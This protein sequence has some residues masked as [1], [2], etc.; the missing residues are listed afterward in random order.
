MSI[1]R[2][3]PRFKKGQIVFTSGNVYNH[4]IKDWDKLKVEGGK[5]GRIIDIEQKSDRNDDQWEHWEYLVEFFEL[6]KSIWLEEVDLS[7]DKIKESLYK[8]LNEI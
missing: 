2:T 4:S 3:V 5:I 6:G 7:Y 1:Y 8:V